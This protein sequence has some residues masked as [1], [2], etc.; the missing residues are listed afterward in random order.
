MSGNGN[1]PPISANEWLARFVTVE[2]WLRSDDTIR[3]DAFI[4]PRDLNLSVTRHLN[5][6]Q[7]QLWE[8]G[9]HVAEA[10]SEKHRANLFGRADLTVA[11][12]ARTA[13][14]VESA[15]IPAN[16]QHAH[17]AGWPLDKPA[18]K[19]IAQQLA[20]AAN[21]IPKPTSSQQQP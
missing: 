7:N 18:Q 4:P 14:R 11:A 13:V 19:S 16:P 2:K 15:P 17:I 6:S 20:A 8:V 12:V 21:F 3:Q 5:L 10:I 1:L 9:Q